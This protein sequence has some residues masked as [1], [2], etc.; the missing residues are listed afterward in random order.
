MTQFTESLSFSLEYL[1]SEFI[2]TAANEFNRDLGCISD[3]DSF[4]NV[5]E[6]AYATLI[7]DQY[8]VLTD[9]LWQLRLPLEWSVSR[10]LA[11]Q[12]DTWLT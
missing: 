4:T 10:R 2:G 6:S 8:K 11:R 7:T 1:A 5:R 9:L 12:T 3:I